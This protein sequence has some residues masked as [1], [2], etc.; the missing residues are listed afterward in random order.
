MKNANHIHILLALATLCNSFAI[1]YA[2]L[3]WK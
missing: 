3:Y 1:I 2:A